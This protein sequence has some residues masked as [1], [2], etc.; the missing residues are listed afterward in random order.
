MEMQDEIKLGTG[1]AEQEKA[2][3]RWQPY[4]GSLSKRIEIRG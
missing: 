3:Y 1:I 2:Q 4:T